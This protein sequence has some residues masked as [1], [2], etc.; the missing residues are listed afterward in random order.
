MRIIILYALSVWVFLV[1]WYMFHVNSD[2]KITGKGEFILLICA[3][4]PEQYTQE[5]KT[6]VS[7]EILC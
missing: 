7:V 1:F 5:K 3:W 4:L 6:L 2:N